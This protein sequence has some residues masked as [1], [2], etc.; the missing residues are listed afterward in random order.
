MAL[1][2]SQ[3]KSDGSYEVINQIEAQRN[4]W[5]KNDITL[6]WDGKFYL[7]GQVPEKPQSVINAERIAE[8]NAN[9]AATDSIVLE[10]V[11]NA[12]LNDGNLVMPAGIDTD[13]ATIISNRA[14]WR[15]ELKQLT[16]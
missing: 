14:S 9:I 15:A 2:Y 4:G 5:C 11:E 3:V 13:Y 10:L 12:L 16:K 7:V 6:G 1:L 8:L